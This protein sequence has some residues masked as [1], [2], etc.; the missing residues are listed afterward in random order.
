MCSTIR[1]PLVDALVQAPESTVEVELRRARALI[2]AARVDEAEAVLDAVSAR[3]QWE[4][5]VAW[6]R[7]LSR[8]STSEPEAALEDFQTVYRTAP[9]ELAVKVALAFAAEAA[10]RFTEADIFYFI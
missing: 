3:D 10:G 4:W 8:L 7:G 2:D 6:Y 9:G 5:R 1:T